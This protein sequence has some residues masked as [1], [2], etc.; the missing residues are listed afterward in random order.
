MHTHT[1]SCTFRTSSGTLTFWLKSRLNDVKIRGTGEES[2]LMLGVI[3]PG[4]ISGGEAVHKGKTV[5][6]MV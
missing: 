5:K 3:D 6:W 2:A 4:T 1:H